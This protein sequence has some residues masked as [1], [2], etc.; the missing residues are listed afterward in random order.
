MLGCVGSVDAVATW[1]EK[2]EALR[3]GRSRAAIERQAGLP[4]NSISNWIND[5]RAV[6]A[7]YGVR[8]ARALGVT[9]DWLFDDEQDLPPPGSG[10]GLTPTGAL[11]ARTRRLVLLAISDALR[12]AA[13]RCDESS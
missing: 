1:A 5:G 7:S 9:S 12:V 10:G 11:D 8:L 3:G 13:E 2:F 4:S 6:R